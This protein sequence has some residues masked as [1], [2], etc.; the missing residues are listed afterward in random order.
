MKKKTEQKTI[1]KYIYT[2]VQKW[3]WDVKSV[4]YEFAPKNTT[5]L[6][7]YF[8]ITIFGIFA[9]F[10]LKKYF[11]DLLH[12]FLRKWNKII[13]R[14]VSTLAWIE[15]N[16][17]DFLN[18]CFCCEVVFWHRYCWYRDAIIENLEIK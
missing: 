1:I 16:K 7:C 2:K 15:N 13:F 3:W 8:K 9:T 17:K 18:N 4:H 11:F 5:L 6:F 12:L 14:I 10:N